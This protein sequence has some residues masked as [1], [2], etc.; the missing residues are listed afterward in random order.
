MIRF[1]TL[2]L[3]LFYFLHSLGCSVQKQDKQTI[4]LISIDGFR[5][6]YPEKAETPNLDFLIKTGVRA[7]SLTPCFPTKT[8]PN[9][10]TIVTGLYPQNHGIIANNMYDPLRKKPFKLSIP[11]AIHDPQ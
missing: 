11:E 6:D 1:S 8:F 10:Y 5:W 9:H 4:I 7:K 3:A 2:L